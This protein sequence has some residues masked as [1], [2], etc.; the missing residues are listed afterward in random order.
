MDRI[1]AVLTLGVAMMLVTTNCLAS[2]NVGTLSFTP[3]SGDY[4]SAFGLSLFNIRDDPVGGYLNFAVTLR[5]REPHYDNLNV[6]SFGDPV[7]DRFRERMVFAIGVTRR[8]THAFAVY[9]GI[10]YGWGEGKA[11]K[12][13]PT[14][15][16]GDNGRSYYVDDPANDEDGVNLNFGLLAMTPIGVTLEAG[17]HSFSSAPYVGAG[18]SF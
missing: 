17:Y 12:Q 6:D 14:G 9:G 5:E 18:W 8:I 13:D 16:L 1:K 3:S 7:T 10:G 11:R 4:E 15:I 2:T